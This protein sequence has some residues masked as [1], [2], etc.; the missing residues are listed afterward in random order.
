MHYTSSATGLAGYPGFQFVAM[1]PLTP[2][3]AAEAVARYLTYQPPP[4]TPAEPDGLEIAQLPVAFGHIH[5]EFGAVLTHCT[6]SGRDYTGRPGNFFGHAVVADADAM[7]GTRPIEFWQAPWWVNYPANGTSDGGPTANLGWSGPEL[8]LLDRLQ[9]GDAVDPHRVLRTLAERGEAGYRLLARIVDAALRA[10]DEGAGRIILI[11]DNVDEI[12]MWIGAVSYSIPYSMANGLSFVTFSADPENTNYRLV[13]TTPDVYISASNA[14]QQFD[15][16]Y[17]AAQDEPL[18]SMFARTVT[19]CWRTGLFTRL[20]NVCRMADAANGL[21]TSEPVGRWPDSASSRTSLRA[22]DRDAAC[23]LALACDGQALRKA[24]VPAIARLMRR[25]SKRLP[26]PVWRAL[27]EGTIDDFELRLEGWRAASIASRTEIADQLGVW[28]VDASVQS[29]LLRPRLREGGQVSTETHAEIRQILEHAFRMASELREVAELA[30]IA[31]LTGVRLLRQSV[32]EA[33]AVCAQQDP[34]GL[35]SAIAAIPTSYSVP[36]RQGVLTGLETAPDAVL[37]ASVN[38][39]T[40]SWLGAQDWR[41]FPRVG[42]RVLL[43]EAAKKPKRRMAAVKQ[44]AALSSF[45]PMST[46]EL[47]EV[48]STLWAGDAVSAGDRVSLLDIADGVSD[49]A[50]Q[51]RIATFA[52]A[53]LVQQ[54]LP[55]EGDY[56]IAK[57]AWRRLQLTPTK[58]VSADTGLLIALYELTH[59]RIVTLRPGWLELLAPHARPDLVAAFVAPAAE[60]ISKLSPV[61]MGHALSELSSETAGGI[62]AG[63]RQQLIMSTYSNVQAIAE[64]AHKV[65]RLHQLGY[66]DDVLDEHLTRLVGRREARVRKALGRR[67]RSAMEVFDRVVSERRSHRK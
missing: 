30:E 36:F 8:P 50:L 18:L 31:N 24:E 52:I 63:V 53:P 2:S 23:L 1:T 6:Y 4:S 20:D 39:S 13:G 45:Q 64:L 38:A 42:R 51:S 67:D 12:A 59:G 65:V 27:R 5:T 56:E 26:E 66:G 62:V 60:A 34:G 40:S 49:Q 44:I 48:L 17:S 46:S 41:S 15:L 54:P 47:D 61:K 32:V 37:R 29:P 3:I 57:R 14:E 19:S 33:S 55:Q 43:M 11:S 7:R 16:R 25:W 9:P 22:A 10:I 21:P 28:C 58:R 35:H